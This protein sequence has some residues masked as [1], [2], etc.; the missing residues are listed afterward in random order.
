MKGKGV[1]NTPEINF[2]L[3][4]CPHQRR[5]QHHCLLNV[6]TRPGATDFSSSHI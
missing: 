2:W 6:P 1:G 5:H 4:L 3:R